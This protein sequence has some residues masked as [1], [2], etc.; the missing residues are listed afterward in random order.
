M[1]RNIFGIFVP[2][3]RIFL[4]SGFGVHWCIFDKE[5]TNLFGYSIESSNK[6][7][8]LFY[9]MNRPMIMI[10]DLFFEFKQKIVMSGDLTVRQSW[11]CKGPVVRGARYGAPGGRG[12]HCRVC[13]IH[14][15]RMPYDQSL[16]QYDSKVVRLTRGAR[17]LLTIQTLRLYSK[18]VLLVKI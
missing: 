12:L 15:H 18:C 17:A 8:V 4:V 2:S 1:C 5:K 7:I 16:S 9:L 11:Q 13:A 14:A 3:I 10:L 6:C